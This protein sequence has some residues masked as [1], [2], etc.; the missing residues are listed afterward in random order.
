M[1]RR[2]ALSVKRRIYG[3]IDT[4][5]DPGGQ[6]SFEQEVHI[7][8]RQSVRVPNLRK[9][10]AMC[11]TA[12]GLLTLGHVYTGGLEVLVPKYFQVVSLE[13]IECSDIMA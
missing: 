11:S 5:I 10:S 12:C 8:E 2:L 4:S 13:G 6:A 7:G 1:G 3:N 9:I